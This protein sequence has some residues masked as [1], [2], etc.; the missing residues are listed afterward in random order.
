M[1]DGYQWKA[2]T[3]K[4]QHYKDLKDELPKCFIRQETKAPK[5]HILPSII[6]LV[7]DR[8]EIFPQES[9]RKRKLGSV[10]CGGRFLEVSLGNRLLSPEMAP[11]ASETS[12]QAQDLRCLAA[13]SPLCSHLSFQNS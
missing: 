10:S 3:I 8:A 9:S 5:G 11:S 6:Q 7:D 1:L 12:W 2:I 4:Y 13:K